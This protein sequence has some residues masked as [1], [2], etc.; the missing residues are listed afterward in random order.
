MFSLKRRLL[1]SH[2][3]VALLGAG[4]LGAWLY[5]AAEREL[6]AGARSRLLDTARLLA[7]GM[8]R[9]ELDSLTTGVIA[10][11]EMDL[12]RRLVDATQSNPDLALAYIAARDGSTP[13]WIA[14][15]DAAELNAHDAAHFASDHE[16]QDLLT[17]SLDKA[18][19]R[20]V[21]RDGQPALLALAPV[22]GQQPANYVVGVRMIPGA[23]TE[24]L[25]VL[26]LSAAGAFL[27]TVLAA[28]IL[29]R[30]ITT[31]FRTR[32]DSLIARCHAL[33]KGEPLPAP[34]RPDSDEVAAV[35]A[36]FDVMAAELRTTQAQREQALAAVTDANAR[37]EQRVRDRTLSLESATHK[38]KGE[39]ETRLQIEALL[40]EAALTDPLT[41]LLNRRAMVEMLGQVAGPGR[42]RHDDLQRSPGRHRLFQTHQRQLRPRRRRPGPGRGR[43]GHRSPARRPAPRRALGR[44]G[45]FPIVSGVAPGR[46][47]SARGRVA[48][49]CTRAAIAD[50]GSAFVGEHRGGGIYSGRA[51]GGLSAALRSGVVSGQGSGAQYRGGG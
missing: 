46:S 50:H 49:S 30:I 44:R 33:G 16:E 12:Q 20:S 7:Q 36:E 47:L 27:V 4:G 15:S 31:R 37:L 39:I 25:N 5:H 1:L 22:P 19:V 35:L 41:G 51:L 23:T 6:D 45:I 8:S 42:R 21:I 11:P 2:L 40:A 34:E 10:T 48:P 14:A 28:L 18:L 43:P 13:H 26:R 29:S 9:S 17:K 32:M 24:R 38:L 3:L